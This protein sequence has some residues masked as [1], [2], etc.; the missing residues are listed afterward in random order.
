MMKSGGFPLTKWATNNWNVLAAFDY[1]DI[2]QTAPIEFAADEIRSVLGTYWNPTADEFLFTVGD[3][4]VTNGITK[5]IATS[6][7]AKL[8][9]PTGLLAAVIAKGKLLI[10]QLW[11]QK[12]DWDEK[13]QEPLLSSWK[14][15]F[16]SM[17]ILVK[18]RVP[19]WISAKENSIIELHGFCD[20]SEALYAAVIYY[21]ITTDFGIRCGILSAKTKVAPLKTISIPRLE[22]CGA[23]LVTRLMASIKN[24]LSERKEIVR[25]HYWTDS[26]IVLAWLMQSPHTLKTFVANRIAKIQSETKY[27]DWSHVRSKSNPADLASRGIDADEII[28][29]ALWWS[30]PSWLSLPNSEW[31]GSQP[32]KMTDTD[33]NLMQIE[34]KSP[35]IASITIDSFWI[36]SRFS[37]FSRLCL[38]TA[39]VMRFINNCRA[40]T[41]ARRTDQI[42]STEIGPL[43]RDEY[44]HAERFWL[45]KSQNV[46]FPNEIKM[47][48]ENG[49]LHKSSKLY[50]LSPFLDTNGLLRVGGRLAHASIPY[51]A[52]YPIILSGNSKIA[53][54]IIQRIHLEMLHGG[55]QLTTRTIREKYW[56]VGGRNAI[57][58]VIHN[59]V[60][61]VTMRA[62][63]CTQQMANLVEERVTPKRPFT[64]VSID[65]CGPFEVK[66][67]SGRCRSLVKVW[68]AVFVC[69]ATRAIH[70]ELVH[71]L[72]SEAFIDA[73]QNFAS[74]RGY[75]AQIISDNAKTFVGAK[76]QMLEIEEI[77]R[78][79]AQASFF[80]TRGIEWKFIMPRSP[81]QGGS[82]E[83][84]VKLFKHHLWR[85]VGANVLSVTELSSLIVRI[86]GCLNSR[87][88][89]VQSDDPNDH[90]VVTPSQLLTGH[91][92]VAAPPVETL[93]ENEPIT[94]RNL[95]KVQY[96]HQDIWRQWQSDYINSLQCRGR[97]QTKQKNLEIDDIVLIKEDNI[98]PQ[99]WLLGRI[100]AT[101]PGTDGCV[102][103]VTIQCGNG[104]SFKRAVQKLVKLPSGQDV[105]AAI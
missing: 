7:L 16:D 92:L 42:V 57:R 100:I 24:A 101:H 35:V 87:P 59:C 5:R 8:F 41:N 51:A 20:A 65:Y 85:V 68:V 44:Q 99:H 90:I 80:V 50:G 9:D 1:E 102:R 15:F 21:R 91:S 25:C 34:K 39:Y 103:N 33:S 26:T 61:C 37:N 47:C 55:S 97:W 29:N 53:K 69:M 52:K 88:L 38:V 77:F 93:H 27:D 73:F 43:S 28:D 70:L 60:K 83:V 96:W 11:L 32:Y 19:R 64:D 3:I 14:N 74:R 95:K 46:D 48:Q 62:K 40:K 4:N 98:A 12:I 54:M 6:E 17:K 23:V 2:P 75:C 72:T 49:N 10:R 18:V 45:I 89:A 81:S 79:S 63:T 22:L 94:N 30:G 84:A 86:E 76:R 104:S 58:N 36:A 78:K 66:R 31:P 105:M 67:Y 71:N 56:I 82:H 13:I